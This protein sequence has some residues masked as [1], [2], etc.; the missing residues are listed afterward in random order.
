MELLGP[1]SS[2]SKYKCA[3]LTLPAAPTRS[4]QLLEVV[5]RLRRVAA[6]RASPFCV[7]DHS[8]EAAALGRPALEGPREVLVVREDA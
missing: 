8:L 5:A 7:Q 4:L 1:F 3:K 6:E 2:A